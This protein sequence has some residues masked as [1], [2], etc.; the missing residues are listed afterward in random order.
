[1]TE[2]HRHSYD[3]FPDANRTQPFGSGATCAYN[4]LDLRIKNNTA[5]PYQLVLGMED[6]DLTGEWRT[7][8]MTLHTYEIYEKEHRITQNLW[9]GYERHNSIYRKV[10]NREGELVQDEFITENRALMMYQ[11]FL[12]SGI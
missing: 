10:F 12:E 1:M 4:Y 5:E 6:R 3:V 7:T 8:Q 9:G 2:R 11:P